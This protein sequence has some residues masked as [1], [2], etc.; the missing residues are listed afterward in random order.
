VY[1]F[2]AENGIG[3]VLPQT[4]LEKTPYEH[5][6]MFLTRQLHPPLADAAAEAL[7]QD[8]RRV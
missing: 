6:Q 3:F 5:A 7:Q 1:T 2:R 4:A 8:G